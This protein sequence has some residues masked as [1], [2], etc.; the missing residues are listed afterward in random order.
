[1]MESCCVIQSA[2]C[3]MKEPI[4]VSII[5]IAIAITTSPVSRITGPTKTRNSRTLEMLLLAY[6]AIRLMMRAGV[7][8]IMV[9]R[10]PNWIE[11][12]IVAA[13]VPGPAMSG[14]ASGTTDSSS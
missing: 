5:C 4:P 14:A 9:E 6:I 2:S 11:N 12:E 13:I 8:A 3:L 1:M 10:N 7:R